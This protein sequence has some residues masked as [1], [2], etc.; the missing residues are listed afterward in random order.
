MLIQMMAGET[1]GAPRDSQTFGII[2]AAM[3]VRA[4]LGHGFLESA[5]QGALEVEFVH[6]AIP[7]VRE[8]GLPIRYR[9]GVEGLAEESGNSGAVYHAGEPVGKCVLRIIQ[10]P[11]SGRVPEP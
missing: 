8:L 11:V 2:G 9:G 1:T 3:A 7:L 6:R 4:E 10:Q 5:Y